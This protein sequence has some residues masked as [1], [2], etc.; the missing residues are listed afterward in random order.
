MRSQPNMTHTRSVEPTT[1]IQC[2]A[3]CG[4][5]VAEIGAGEAVLPTRSGAPVARWLE[6]ECPCGEKYRLPVVNQ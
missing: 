3:G 4:R 1:A 5:V 6:G 2:P